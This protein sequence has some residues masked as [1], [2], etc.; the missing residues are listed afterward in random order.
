MAFSLLSVLVLVFKLCVLHRL[1]MD[2][3]YIL[4]NERVRMC[5]SVVLL[6][7]TSITRHRGAAVKDDKGVLF[8][9]LGVV[10][11]AVGDSRL[12]RPHDN[13]F[14][15]TGSRYFFWTLFGIVGRSCWMETMLGESSLPTLIS[16]LLPIE[17]LST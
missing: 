8:V 6:L 4:S 5:V 15:L 14:H 16:H 1:S 12:Y 17:N 11:N 13:Y 9:T 2:I 10:E 3:F 7:V